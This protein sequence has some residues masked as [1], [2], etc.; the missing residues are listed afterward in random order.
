MKINNLEF[1]NE[2]MMDKLVEAGCKPKIGRK[3]IEIAVNTGM[4]QTNLAAT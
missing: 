1:K 4:M 2:N 3:Q